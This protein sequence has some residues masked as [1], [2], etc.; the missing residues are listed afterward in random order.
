MAKTRHQNLILVLILPWLKSATKVDIQPDIDFDVEIDIEFD[1]EFDIGGGYEPP[2]IT[3]V[4]TFLPSKE[5]G[6]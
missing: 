5:C 2:Y 3:Y 6:I 4:S 1:I